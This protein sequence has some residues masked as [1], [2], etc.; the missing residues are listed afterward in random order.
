M[1]LKVR[2]TVLNEIQRLKIESEKLEP[3]SEAYL[4]NAKAIS[5]LSDSAK[6][7][8]IVD[9]NQLIP[10]IVS[11]VMFVLYM[12]LQESRIMDLRSITAIKNLFRK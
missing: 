10:A 12:I 6:K 2:K 5:Q 3:G 1:V 4:T 7:L 8:E 9:I 11:V